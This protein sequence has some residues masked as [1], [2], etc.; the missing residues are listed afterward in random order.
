LG[1]QSLL[2][3]F[4]AAALLVIPLALVLR[5]FDAAKS[6]P[7]APNFKEFPALGIR[8]HTNVAGLKLASKDAIE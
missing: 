3:S 5:A 2:S 7:R 8:A 4:L 1:G 6:L